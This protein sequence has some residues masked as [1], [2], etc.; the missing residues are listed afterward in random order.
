MDFLTASQTERGADLIRQWKHR[1]IEAAVSSTATPEEIGAAF[2]D[3]SS[4]LMQI[5]PVIVA[6]LTTGF[7]PA[8]LL[9]LI[10][11]IIGILFPNLDAG[12][13]ELLKQILAFF[14]KP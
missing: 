11:T 9:A 3:I 12:L 7:T 2:P 6:L 14:I 13:V 1:C 8:A 10:P 4:V 5:L